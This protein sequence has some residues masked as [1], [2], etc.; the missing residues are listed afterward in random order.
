MCGPARCR[1]FQAISVPKVADVQQELKL[2]DAGTIKGYR[3][4]YWYLLKDETDALDPKR[5]VRSFQRRCVAY[6]PR[7]VGYAFSS[8]PSRRRECPSVGLPNL[9]LQRPRQEIVEGNI[10]DMATWAMR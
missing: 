3:V 6:R 4:A 8:A 7:V 1:F 9:R 2:V 5:G 10:D